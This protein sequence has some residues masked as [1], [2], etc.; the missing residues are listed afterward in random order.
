VFILLVILGVAVVGGVLVAL[1]QAGR[2]EAAAERQ[3][4][5]EQARMQALRS[6]DAVWKMDYGEFEDHVAALCRRDGCTDVKRVGGPRDRGADVIGF[7]P[8]GRKIVVQCKR[9]ARERKV[10]SPD[11]QRFNG[12]ARAE[13]GADV[14]L[15]IASC[16]FTRDARSFAAKHKLVLVDVDLLAFWNNGMSLLSFLDLDISRSGNNRRIDPD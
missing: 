3:R 12:T 9:Y 14:P 7:L 5:A 15:I 10:G 13:H 4:L 6:M 1:I 2:R 16:K 8:D 11:A